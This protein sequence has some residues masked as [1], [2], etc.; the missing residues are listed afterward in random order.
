[1]IDKTREVYKSLCRRLSGVY[2]SYGGYTELLRSPFFHV[3]VVLGALISCFE[4][5]GWRAYS[6]SISPSLLGFTLAA[7]TVFISTVPGKVLR[8]MVAAKSEDGYSYF[9]KINSAF[10]HFIFIQCLALLYA[11]SS[12]FWSQFSIPL[13]FGDSE[14][15]HLSNWLGYRAL[16]LIGWISSIYAVTL[17]LAILIWVYRIIALVEA[18][19]QKE[20]DAE[21]NDENEK[22]KK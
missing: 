18:N 5:E 12:G 8:A 21:K 10:F 15:L 2:K 17:V 3:A 22:Q 7:Y 6:V 11:L 19:V 4:V 9:S 1:M 14:L 16:N 20:I 13:L